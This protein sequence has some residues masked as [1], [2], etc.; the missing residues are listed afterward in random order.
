MSYSEYSASSQITKTSI[1]SLIVL[2]IAVLEGVVR[3][4]LSSD[5]G[6][7]LVGLRDVCAFTAICCSIVECRNRF[8]P[9]FIKITLFWSAFVVFWGA[10][11]ILIN[12][13]SIVVFFIGIRFWLLY[14]LFSVFV[15]SSLSRNELKLVIKF[16]LFFMVVS[17]PLV[18]F[19]Y[20]SP[21]EHFINKQVDSDSDGVFLVA[22]NIVRTTG[23]FSFTL[24]QTT[25]LSI[26]NGVVFSYI[27]RIDIYKRKELISA[28]LLFLMLLINTIVSGSRAAIVLFV[29]IMIIY[30]LFEFFFFKKKIN[31]MNF[32]FI[33]L[34]FFSIGAS[35]FLFSRA[36]NATQ[37]RF[38]NA[39]DEEN[40]S[41]RVSSLLIGEPLVFDSFT[42]IGEGI[43]KGTNFAA[44]LNSGTRGFMLAETEPG[45][46]IL[47]GG[48]LGA[49]FIA[50]KWI[51]F[52]WLSIISLNKSFSDRDSSYILYCLSVFISFITSSVTGQLTVNVLSSF[53]LIIFIANISFSIGKYNN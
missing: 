37:E 28:V 38:D 45:R 27:S 53:I 30:I 40:I 4:W 29:F 17:T 23:F 44:M 39:S 50:I 43:G 31:R 33:M 6:L 52:L 22:E 47:E 12:Q 18:F 10:L 24:G 7:L 34:M 25:Y 5:F 21:V 19:Q 48:L 15:G 35:P 51:C 20:I 36:I 32:L 11:Q 42:W 9:F 2:T 3:K 49:L 8:N 1:L 41:D 46:N 26:M 14:F 13:T 16:L